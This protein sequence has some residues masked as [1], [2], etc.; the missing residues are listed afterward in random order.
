M[1]LSN[2]WETMQNT[3][4]RFHVKKTAVEIYLTSLYMLTISMFG[5]QNRSSR[6]AV[7]EI[8]VPIKS[9][10]AQYARKK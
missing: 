10:I 3:K 9:S 2:T 8:S 4:S 1:N 7:Q 6:K 5:K